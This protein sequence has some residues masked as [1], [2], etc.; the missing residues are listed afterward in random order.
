MNLTEIIALVI[1]TA[2]I[3]FAGISL[4][5]SLLISIGLRGRAKIYVRCGDCNYH[6]KEVAVVIPAYMESAASILRTLKNIS[7]FNYPKELVKVYVVIEEDDEATLRS[8]S[9][10]LN[11]INLGNIN[12]IRKPGPRSGKASALNYAISHIKEPI[13]CVIDSDVE[14]LDRDFLGKVASLLSNGFQVI[15]SKICSYSNN[16]IGELS[17]VDTL[18]WFKL[19]LPSL[20]KFS[21][22]PI[23]NSGLI[24][25]HREFL[26][27]LLPLPQVLTE[28]AYLTIKYIESG[29][30]V[31]ILDSTAVKAA[32][33]SVGHL[34]RQRLRW[35]RGYYQCALKTLKSDVKPLIKLRLLI[36]YLTPLA[37]ISVFLSLTS[38]ATLPPILS[39]ITDSSIYMLTS[40]TIVSSAAA[41]TLLISSMYPIYR[42]LSGEVLRPSLRS[43]ILYPLFMALQGLIA[44]AALI[45][46]KVKWYKTERSENQ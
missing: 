37:M 26:T 39:V 12:I 9:T 40:L 29:S 30:K 46:P 42:M 41:L 11:D 24:C 36:L 31:G 28:D 35:F 6:S 34:I 13:V 19:T 22:Y 7:K 21:K 23:L 20:S 8:L 15:G 5:Y 2:T 4:I 18:T 45:L 32:P 3:T 33:K 44:L 10:A 38:L 14:V 17:Y 43:V 16:L 1:D 25:L 27:R